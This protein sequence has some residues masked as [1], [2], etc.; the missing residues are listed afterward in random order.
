MALGAMFDE[1]DEG[2]AMYKLTPLASGVPQQSP[3][4]FVYLDMPDSNSPTGYN[5]PNDWY[6][7]LANCGTQV[8][9]GVSIPMA[10]MPIS[11]PGAVPGC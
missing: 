1:V 11:P 7:K 6:L 4:A 9:H 3:A 5:L 8:I 10:N 2:T